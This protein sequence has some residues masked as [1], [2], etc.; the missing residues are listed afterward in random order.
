MISIV[1][2][3]RKNRISGK[4]VPKKTVE[5]EVLVFFQIL[6]HFKSHI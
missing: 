2:I 5:L 1:R 4:R 6:L 3:S